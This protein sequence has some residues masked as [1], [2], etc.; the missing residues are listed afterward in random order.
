LSTRNQIEEDKMKKWRVMPVVLLAV[1]N[2]A[3]NIFSSSQSTPST[4]STVM[5]FVKASHVTSECGEW[6][7]LGDPV[8][9]NYPFFAIASNGLVI[10]V[11][12]DSLVH[13]YT[14]EEDNMSWSTIGDPINPQFISSTSGNNWNYSLNLSSDGGVIAI[15]DGDYDSSKG[16]VQVFAVNNEDTWTL[17]GSAIDGASVDDESGSSASISSNGLTLVIGA[18]FNDG[19]TFSAGHARVFSYDAAKKLWIQKGEDINGEER[20]DMSGS[21]VSISDDGSVVAVGAHRNDG[22]GTESGHVRVYKFADNSWIQ[23]GDDLDGEA[24]GDLSGSSIDM[25][26]NGDVI[27]IGAIENDDNGIDSGHVRVYEYNILDDN[28][29]QRGNDIDGTA[30]KDRSGYSVD[31]ST[32][33]MVVAI[34]SS[35]SK[36][37]IYKRHL[38]VYRYSTQDDRWLQRG[39]DLDV[40]KK[41]NQLGID[42]AMAADGTVVA[43]NGYDTNKLQIMKWT[44]CTSPPS[45]IPSGT[46]IPPTDQPTSSIPSDTPSSSTDQPT[47]RECSY[48][49]KERCNKRGC[50]WKKVAN[51]AGICLRCV[52]IKN[53][54]ICNRNGCVWDKN[55]EVQCNSCYDILKR[56]NCV[57]SGC[58]WEGTRKDGDCKSCNQIVGKKSC[59]FGNCAYHLNTKRCTTC[60]QVVKAK[61]CRRQKRCDWKGRGKCMRV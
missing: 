9:V 23:R 1:Q 22:N 3:S 18:S 20:F 44:T 60:D 47:K 5:K 27:A 37:K 21:S 52:M 40:D 34:G 36:R 55:E 14:F 32:D 31:I 51:D 33:G 54:E 39:V 53:S 50:V 7:Q 48:N 45:S 11:R 10:A 46:P 17:L 43:S 8:N 12:Q 4:T 42:V 38:R 6:R 59:K 56:T 26:G 58:V 35:Y 29:M 57:A 24:R 19:D 13:V 30:A 41:H 61:E 49:E 28:W 2:L 25:S 15:G 16:R